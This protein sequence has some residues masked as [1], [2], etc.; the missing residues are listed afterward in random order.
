MPFS[1][2][3]CEAMARD[4]RI[5]PKAP[6]LVDLLNSAIRGEVDLGDGV[7]GEEAA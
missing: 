3:A 5:D 6:G 2:P 4:G 1:G 7:L